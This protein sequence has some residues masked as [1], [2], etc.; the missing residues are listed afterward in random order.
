MF[1]TL[2]AFQF[3]YQ[4]ESASRLTVFLATATLHNLLPFY[5]IKFALEKVE[6]SRTNASLISS[7][8]ANWH[9]GSF[10]AREPEIL[11][12]R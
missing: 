1:R 12:F 10:S 7:S 11:P 8:A 9:L 5:I 2:D 6:G 4:S 3:T